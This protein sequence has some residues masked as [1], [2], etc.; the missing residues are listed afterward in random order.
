M[1]CYVNFRKIRQC[2]VA[3]RQD[4]ETEV[5]WDTVVRNCQ[6]YSGSIGPVGF[7]AD[8]EFSCF[9]QRELAEKRVRLFTPTRQTQI[10][11][12]RPA[13]PVTLWLFEAIARFLWTM[14]HENSLNYLL[15]VGDMYSE[16]T[17][18]EDISVTSD[19]LLFWSSNYSTNHKGWLLCAE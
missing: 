2:C 3:K 1:K 15:L 13:P 16:S 6:N 18:P 8:N 9:F 12:Q 10:R 5:F 7:E 14:S 19:A 11:C 4:F 17:D